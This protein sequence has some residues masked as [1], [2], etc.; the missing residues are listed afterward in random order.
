MLPIK[1]KLFLN[2]FIIA[3]IVAVLLLFAI[4]PMKN[5]I[6]DQSGALEKK[7]S[8]LYSLEQRQEHFEKLKTKYQEIEPNLNLLYKNFLKNDEFVDFIVQLENNAS[9]TNNKQEIKLINKEQQTDLQISLGGS[10]PN[11]IRFLAQLE[12]SIPLI[13]VESFQIT[14][15]SKKTLGVT[16]DLEFSPGDVKSIL[17]IKVLAA[18]NK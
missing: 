2:S 18:E 16:G 4:S 8:L 3:A 11:L 14:R 6:V 15:V 17:N 7:R 9:Q 13:T 5:K 1:Q 10:F 12:N